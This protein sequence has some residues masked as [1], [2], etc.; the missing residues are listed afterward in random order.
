M[1]PCCIFYAV[2]LHR[3]KILTNKQ[4]KMKSMILVSAIAMLVP[5]NIMAQNDSV[6][7]MKD[8]QLK[9]VTITTRRAGTVK[10]RGVANADLINSLELLKA[11]CCNLGE[12]FT[13]NP[14]V[15]VSYSDAA[16]G[17]R[18]IKLLGLSGTYVQMLSENVPN[19]RGTASPYSLG[20]IPGPWMSGIQVSKGSSSVKNGYESITGQINIGF[21][22]PQETE[23]VNF[24][25]YMNSMAKTDVNADAN[26]HVNDKLSTGLMLHYEDN[27]RDHDDNDDGFIDEP[28][29]R[30]YN[31]QNKWAYFGDRYILHAYIRALKEK[32][33]GG[34]LSRH[35]ASS[36]EYGLFKIGMETDRID[37][38]AKN[39]FI[40][41]KEHNSNVA[42]VLSGTLHKLSSG[43]GMKSYDVNE[44][45]AYVSLMFET[46]SGK[47][48]SLS[49]GIS[50]SHDYYDQWLED[51][52]STGGKSIEKETTPGAYVQYTYNLDDKLIAMGGLRMD[53]SSVYGTF[54]TPRAHVKW[55]PNDVI[56]L[57][58]SAGE[59]YRT[60][61]ALAE[62]HYLLASGRRLLIDDLQQERAWNYGMSTA[63]YIPLF[64]KT[65][66]LNAEYFYTDFRQQV[67]IDYDSDSE[68]IHIT[69][70]Q[71]KSYSH[72][73]QADA[74]YP[75][76]DGM[77]LTAAYRRNYAKSTYGGE[78]MERPLT[79]R[80][81]G[82]LTASYKTPLGLWQFDAT[83][84][85]NGGG[86]M[87]TPYELPD[88]TE[89]WARSFGSYEQVSAQITRWF[90][91][92][93][94]YLGAENLTGFRQ[95][96]PIIDAADPWS[97]TFEPTMVWGPVQGRMFY[98]GIRI[99]FEKI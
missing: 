30:Q 63:L 94:V 41:D 83:L 31:L 5:K 97:S 35:A 25:L 74:S 48:H 89:S 72:T 24:N 4:K 27:F 23:Q 36:Q 84:Q 40:I 42:L 13:T 26:I 53:H 79:S 99:N 60:V 87:P 95:K 3:K 51:N 69:N 49:T 18:Q 77:T 1:Q 33:E 9:E 17:A 92:F 70:L 73:W 80:Y 29:V 50:L 52:V 65:L 10:S 67:I 11:A 76:F 54:V 96:K 55:S 71:G 16:T 59:G 34:Q 62:N 44:R 75:V 7:E 43:F 88:G 6:P 66:N 22:E 47:A 86:R 2:P 68:E 58:A 45:N 90:R 39:A 28:N 14:S 64:G 8:Q 46:E 57:R 19:Y 15:D 37:V 56:S 20:Y 85:L 78:L 61:H 93:S 82:L 91:H 12:S 32:R 98:A 38:T 21:K 81:K